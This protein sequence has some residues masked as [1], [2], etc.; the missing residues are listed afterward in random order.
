MFQIHS[1]T[2]LTQTSSVNTNNHTNHKD[3]NSNS[4]DAH[5]VLTAC[6]FPVCS[7]LHAVIKSIKM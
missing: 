1:N 5:C 6:S 4:D 2:L 3:E 7:D